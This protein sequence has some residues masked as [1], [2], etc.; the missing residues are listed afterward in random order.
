MSDSLALITINLPACNWCLPIGGFQ[1]F[2]RPKFLESIIPE[3]S[4][5]LWRSQNACMGGG[6]KLDKIHPSSIRMGTF[7]LVEQDGY[8]EIMCSKIRN[9]VL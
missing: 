9:Q 5:H 3:I 4:V 6:V 8:H 7:H 2:S 1:P